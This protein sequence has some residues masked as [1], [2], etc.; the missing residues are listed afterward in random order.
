MCVLC[1]C[2]RECDAFYCYYTRSSYDSHE[3]RIEL[4]SFVAAHPFSASVCFGYFSQFSNCIVP[5]LSSYK[6]MHPEKCAYTD[7]TQLT[8][9]THINWIGIPEKGWWISNSFYGCPIRWER[10]ACFS[11]LNSQPHTVH[12]KEQHVPQACLSS[13]NEIACERSRFG[14]GFFR[15][16]NF[17]YIYSSCIELHDTLCYGTTIIPCTIWKHTPYIKYSLLEL[18]L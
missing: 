2:R 17:M 9:L 1:V 6:S 14:A 13:I 7:A 5:E 10:I 11:G 12:T 8:R 15:V 16:F 3:F 4:W 18:Q